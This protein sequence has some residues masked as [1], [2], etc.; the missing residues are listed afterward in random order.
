MHRCD[1]PC[2]KQCICDAFVLKHPHLYAVVFRAYAHHPVS[3]N[4]RIG[5]CTNAI[6]NAAS[7]YQLAL[8]SSRQHLL[9][10]TAELLD[11]MTCDYMGLIGHSGHGRCPCA[12]DDL[13]VTFL[14]YRLQTG[15]K[16]RP[17]SA[18]W[19]LTSGK[20]RPSTLSRWRGTWLTMSI[21]SAP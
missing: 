8:I 1:G 6:H 21:L 16:Y 15:R 17:C 12:Q 7:V 5:Y 4:L 10:I 3:S 11:D 14:L 20:Y 9:K 19:P 2:N 18:L 13:L